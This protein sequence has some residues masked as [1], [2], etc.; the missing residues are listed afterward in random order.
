[1]Y[2]CPHCDPSVD[3]SRSLDPGD[4]CSECGRVASKA[5]A[6]QWI[7]VARV[8]N[9]AEAGFICDELVGQ[10]VEARVHHLEDFDAASHRQSSWYL[11]RVPADFAADASSHVRQFLS[12]EIDGQPTLLDRFRFIAG[13]ADGEPISWRPIVLIALAGVTS[14]VLGQRFSQDR[15]DQWR[16]PN[17]LLS[18]LGEISRP[19]TTDPAA[20]QP[21]YQLS[22]D[23]QQQAWTLGTD[24][25]NDGQFESAEHFRASGA[26][27]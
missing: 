20:N 19:L 26:A 21:R 7:D 9:L 3:L 10:G 2:V 14:F 12:E 11:I 8:A 5:D 13:V 24:R 17:P 6:N 1:M 25:D 27:R 16:P 15:G 18:T 22:Y 4:S 23:Q